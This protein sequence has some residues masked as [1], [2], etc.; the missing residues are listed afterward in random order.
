MRSTDSTPQLRH[1][2]FVLKECRPDIRDF[3]WIERSRIFVD[4]CN[5]FGATDA[6]E[7][8]DIVLDRCATCD[9][10]R[11]TN[12]AFGPE[13]ANSFRERCGICP[14]DPI[15]GVD[16]VEDQE[17]RFVNEGVM[18]VAGVRIDEFEINRV[19]IR[20][21]DINSFLENLVFRESKEI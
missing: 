9:D 6:P 21:E 13:C 10:L 14:K 3:R 18:L 17:L 11:L 1:R 8:F 16:F 20:Q 4:V 15:I 19:R 12:A 5:V 7:Q 2:N